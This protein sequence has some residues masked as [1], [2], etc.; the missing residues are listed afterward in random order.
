MS[1]HPQPPA[2]WPPLSL[3]RD[4]AVWLHIL[5]DRDY[6]GDMRLA[7]N[8][9]LRVVMAQSQGPGEPWAALERR[10]RGRV[11]GQGWRPG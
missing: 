3:D 9:M 4:V 7:L 11:Q 1:V 8:E 5:A 10:H 2:E 6:D